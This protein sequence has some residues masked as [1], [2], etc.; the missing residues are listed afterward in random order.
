MIETAKTIEQFW[1]TWSEFGSGQ[2][3]GGYRIRAVSRGL[4]DINSERIRTLDR[5]A[6][7]NLPEQTN[8]LN[9][10]LE[11]GKA[12][13]TLGLSPDIRPY[14]HLLEIEG[15]PISF[16]LVETQAQDP[17][18]SERIFV[19]KVYVGKDK[20]GR[21][22]NFFAHILAGLPQEFTA[23]DTIA[24]WRS[25]IWQTSD[26]PPQVAG[27]VIEAKSLYELQADPQVS[28]TSWQHVHLPTLND[29]LCFVIHAYLQQQ[30]E[31]DERWQQLEEKKAEFNRLQIKRE[32]LTSRREIAQ[33]DKAIAAAEAE[34]QKLV[35]KR[36]GASISRPKPI[37]SLISLRN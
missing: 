14:S 22:G 2:L 29:Y 24:L 11:Q 3:N 21:P 19:N 26:P 35:Q 8:P 36:P 23:K 1:Y 27:L 18:L 10:I 9:S 13:Y 34:H 30:D 25:N 33:L 7:Y 12:Y 16:A 4:T 15:A 31:E 5:Y 28:R 6:R 32:A 20:L 17:R 37:G